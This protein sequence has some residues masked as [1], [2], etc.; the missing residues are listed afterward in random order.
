MMFCGI[1]YNIV[2]VVGPFAPQH[3]LVLNTNTPPLSPPSF[4]WL[5]LLISPQLPN[6]RSSIHAIWALSLPRCY[7]FLASLALVAIFW[8]L[9]ACENT[10]R[11]SKMLHSILLLSAIFLR[12][13]TCENT[14]EPLKILHQTLPPAFCYNILENRNMLFS[15][16]H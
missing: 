3:F 12:I 9:V 4:H 1:F 7:T 13:V 11:P 15:R 2:A 6:I 5:Q 16:Q 8:K 14:S 10:S